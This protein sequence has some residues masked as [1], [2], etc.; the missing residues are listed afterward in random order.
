MAVTLLSGAEASTD[1]TAN[2]PRDMKGIFELEPNVAPL[3]L[4]MSKLRK[5][6]AAN[7]L[8]EWLE[9]ESM[10]RL[11][12]LSASATSAATALGVTA[13][14]FRVGDIVRITET[15]EAVEVTATAAGAVTAT[16]SIGRVA[17]ASATSAAELF[18]VANANAEGSTL[19]Q[20]KYPQLVTAS[21]YAEIVRTPS[22]RRLVYLVSLN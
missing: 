2:N 20:I 18:I 4:L 8:V 17:D 10:P 16:R 5:E 15:G 11:T 6:A 3:T 13:D 7:P 12:T 1:N 19:R 14:I 21:N 9:D 22:I